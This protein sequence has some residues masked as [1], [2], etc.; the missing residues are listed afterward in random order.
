MGFLAHPNGMGCAPSEIDKMTM[1]EISFWIDQMN[2][3]NRA[4][5]G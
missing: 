4:A 1:D 2:T 3:L 5:N